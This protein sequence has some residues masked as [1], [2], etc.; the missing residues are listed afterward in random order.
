MGRARHSRP[1][2]VPSGLRPASDTIVR[3]AVMDP[4]RW[5]QIEALY[6]DILAEP[7]EHRAALLDGWCAHNSEL[8]RELESLLDAHNEAGDFL[9]PEHLRGQME[10]VGSPPAF[11]P[12]GSS[13]GQY[14][15]LELLGSGG[16]G[17]VYRARDARLD[18]QVALKV[19]PADS[20]DLERV[21]RFRREARAASG[22][23]HPNLVTTYEIGQAGDTWFI[24]AELIKGIGLVLGLAMQRDPGLR[25]RSMAEFG[26]ALQDI[27]PSRDLNRPLPGAI[28]L[29]LRRWRIPGAALGGIAALCAILWF[30]APPAA[31][32]DHETPLQVV[33]LTAFPGRKDFPAL[34]PDGNQVAFAWTGE[35]AA[36]AGRHIY[37][38][39]VRGGEPR[40]LS[41][42]EENDALPAWSPDSREIAFLRRISRSEFEVHTVPSSGGPDRKITKAGD[43][44]GWSPYGRS[45]AIA[46]VP[47]SEGNAGIHIYSLADSQDH[48]L[49]NEPNTTDT[50]P[51]WSPDGRWIAF[52]RTKPANEIYVVASAW[53]RKPQAAKRLTFDK[54]YKQ[55][56][57]AWTPDSREILYSTAREYGG[58][59]LWRVP[60][61]G[62]AAR[63]VSS[64]LLFAGN[65]SLSRSGTRLAYTDSWIDT[66]I[67]VSRGHGF[68]ARGIPGPF[69]APVK[70][71]S[72]SREDH[73]PTFSPAGQ[74][75]A[76]VSNRT[77]HS[78]IWSARSDGS[79]Q[80]QLTRLD[81]FAGTPRWSPDGRWIAFDCIMDGAANVYVVSADGSSLRK[82]TASG[83][84]NTKPSWSVDGKFVYF[85]SD[86]SGRP[87]IWR[88]P[89]DGGDAVQ[90]T[91]EGGREPLP[92][93]DGST[94]YYTRFVG[95]SPVW[96]VLPGGEQERPLAGME[97][98][99]TIGRAWG[100][101][102]QGIYFSPIGRDG[103]P[104]SI[105]FFSF[106]RVGL[107]DLSDWSGPTSWDGP[108]IALSPDGRTL[109]TV[110]TDQ[111]IN[112]L[113]MIENFR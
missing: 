105:R 98:V 46:G 111:E 68:D 35:G 97:A 107:Y 36:N 5:K 66:N 81:A 28:P 69:G 74:Q 112:D 63:R 33:P 79:Q 72:S 61:N 32:E 10:P 14:Q 25:Y 15:T 70:L 48:P 106:S 108:A 80:I 39:P 93:A 21:S 77:G 19:L 62:G 12:D 42:G 71:I 58:E 95:P 92:S 88:I 76:F 54:R 56:R 100:V 67:Y 37:V 101:L 78:E 73:S 94:V 64:T 20:A 38:K 34:S 4:D 24:A 85:N 18:R 60:V 1:A 41:F 103:T 16:M 109:L 65:P 50:A 11:L 91:R 7:P 30:R 31:R 49:T 75:I 29:R 26:R 96:S 13:L 8:R 23:S 2:C 83:E 57:L 89:V 90:I 87:Q 9:S 102:P 104:H 6:H 52:I 27:D 113:M 82:L 17:V 55:R 110:R 44:V 3:V 47:N 53:N 84:P 22:L 45:L 86:R 51:A 59:G 43:G 99:D 40:Q